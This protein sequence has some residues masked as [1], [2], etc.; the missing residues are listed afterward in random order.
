MCGS[1]W[2]QA[3]FVWLVFVALSSVPVAA[4]GP[5]PSR[6]AD[7]AELR[8][9][10]RPPAAGAAQP[11]TQEVTGPLAPAPAPR[12]TSKALRGTGLP[13]IRETF[14]EFQAKHRLPGAQDRYS[15]Q[16]RQVAL[17]E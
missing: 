12:E 13:Q 15:Y 10:S 17:N 11:Q 14:E 8:S 9:T 3:S 5:N 2:L 16:G 6:S 1:A 7:D 4:Q